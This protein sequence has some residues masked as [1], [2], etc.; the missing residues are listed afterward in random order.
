[1]TGHIPFI[2]KFETS[3]TVVHLLTSRP[4]KR[5]SDNRRCKCALLPFD[6]VRSQWA[7]AHDVALWRWDVECWCSG[8]SEDDDSL[9]LAEEEP[10]KEGIEL[11]CTS[12]CM[13]AVELPESKVHRLLRSMSLEEAVQ[14]AAPEN[15]PALALAAAVLGAFLGS[16]RLGVHN[17]LKEV[18]LNGSAEPLDVR[19]L[20]PC[21]GLSTLSPEPRVY[22]PP[23]RPYS[24][25]NRPLPAY[26]NTLW[27]ADLQSV[28]SIMPGAD[29][30]AFWSSTLRDCL[31]REEDVCRRLWEKECR[32]WNNPRSASARDAMRQM[33]RDQAISV[34]QGLCT[35]LELGPL[36][37]ARS[38]PGPHVFRS[39]AEDE[40]TP[41]SWAF[42]PPEDD[43]EFGTL[44]YEPRFFDISG[45]AASADRFAELAKV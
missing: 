11:F 19:M 2:R 6:R 4:A 7:E 33:A 39:P 31:F 24:F 32:G 22:V 43:A 5:F 40:S 14:E 25:E 44:P 37:G 21:I 8:D 10:V 45:S 41:V 34:M 3:L 30:A 1:M 27:P 13:E 28:I 12:R 38:H 26:A 17:D 23:A 35:L 29:N 36:I 18:R 42:W 9:C 20:S 16:L 15:E